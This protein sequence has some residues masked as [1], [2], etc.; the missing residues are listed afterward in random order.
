MDQILSA[1]DFAKVTGVSRE[2][3]QMYAEWENLLTHWNKSINLVQKGTLEQFW[4][5]HAYDSAQICAHIPDQAKSCLDL[6]SGAGFPGLAVAIGLKQ[7]GEAR[8]AHVDLVESNGKKCSFLRA[9]IRQLGLPAKV[10]QR[11]AENLPQTPYDVISARAF[12]PLPR[13]LDYA[14]PF[15]GTHTTG[16]FLKGRQYEGEIKQALYN[17]EFD[18]QVFDSLSSEDGK[19]LVITGLKRRDGEAHNNAPQTVLADKG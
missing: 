7:S 14:A 15:W 3:L 10:L 9:V 11:R 4:G 1:Q 13:L 18:T 12:A 17:Y 5:R 2:T 8:G 19:I 6:G 16:V